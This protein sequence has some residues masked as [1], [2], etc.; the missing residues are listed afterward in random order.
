[1]VNGPGAVT[2]ADVHDLSTVVTFAAPG[3]YTLRLT[4]NDTEFTVSDDVVITVH[5]ENQPPVV[6]AGPD[7]T[8]RLP[9]GAAL[10]GTATDDGW[11]FGSTLTTVV[12]QSVWSRHRHF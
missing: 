2:F 11:P 6:N 8:L 9:A 12:D 4:A 3:D 1:M 5:P 10:N 7:Q